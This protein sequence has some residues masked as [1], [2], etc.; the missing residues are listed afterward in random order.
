MISQKEQA[1]AA[2]NYLNRG[3]GAHRYIKALERRL[4]S[5]TFANITKY[6]SDGA[7]RVEPTENVTE[8]KMLE[9]SELNRLIEETRAK[10]EKTKAETLKT[11][12]KVDSNLQ[13]AILVSRYING[14]NWEQT[15][16]EVDYSVAHVQRLHGQALLSLY[17]VLDDEPTAVG[18]C[19]DIMT[20]K[21]A[22]AVPLG[23]YY[24]YMS[25]KEREAVSK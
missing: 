24:R 12:N 16:K 2:K 23:D 15:A 21:A 6:E 1:A 7:A 14:E 13:K 22:D 9:Y 19:D 17:K 25:A 18:G 10:I 8:T 11:I 20:D 4:N 3:I 5:F